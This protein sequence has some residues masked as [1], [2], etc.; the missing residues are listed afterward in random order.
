MK[1]SKKRRNSV[2]V[3]TARSAVRNVGW[4][5]R[6]DLEI[7]QPDGSES[8]RSVRYG[9]RAGKIR[10]VESPDLLRDLDSLRSM[11]TQAGLGETSD[12]FADVVA[13]RVQMQ[14][15]GWNVC[16]YSSS[17]YAEVLQATADGLRSAGM[18]EPR[19]QEFVVPVRA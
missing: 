4:D 16:P 5:P 15:G 7:L 19:V 18:Q 6:Y 2:F 10:L 1:T 13:A 8:S 14:H 9:Y 11:R 12:C 17:D 3:E